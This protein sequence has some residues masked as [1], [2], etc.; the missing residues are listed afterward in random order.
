MRHFQSPQ[1]L[2]FFLQSPVLFCKGFVASLQI[3]A[4]HF[5]LLQL[6]SCSSVLKP[7]FYLTG[8]EVKLLSQCQLLLRIKGIVLFEAFFQIGRLLFGKAKLFSG[9]APIFFVARSGASPLQFVVIISVVM[10]PV[11]L[12]LD[13]TTSGM[14]HDEIHLKRR[15]SAVGRRHHC[16]VV[17]VVVCG[18]GHTVHIE[19]PG[20][21]RRCGPSNLTTRSAFS[22]ISFTVSI[23][24]DRSASFSIG[25]P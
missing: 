1:F 17:V 5:R 8:A 20:R 15:Y 14:T 2:N 25:L 3:F 7:H 9:G 18:G 24:R 6:R 22:V 10:L 16:I 19:T 4:V 12:P 21:R 11:S 13:S 23:F